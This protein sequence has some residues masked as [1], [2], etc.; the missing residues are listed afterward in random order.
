MI[1]LSQAIS[2]EPD[3]EKIQLRESINLF[4]HIFG[5]RLPKGPTRDEVKQMGGIGITALLMGIFFLF[6]SLILIAYGYG[7]DIF[8]EENC[9]PAL[10]LYMGRACLI[11]SVGW[12]LV[13]W[14]EI[15]KNKNLAKNKIQKPESPWLWKVNW[16]M[17]GTK[18]D[19]R[20]SLYV[21]I[22]ITVFGF[23]LLGSPSWYFITEGNQ[24]EGFG[25]FVISILILFDLIFVSAIVFFVYKSLKFFKYGIS[26]FE[27]LEFPFFTNGAIK[28]QLNNLPK[29][30]SNLTLDLRFIQQEFKIENGRYV[31]NHFQL[32][33]ASKAFRKTPENWK[34]E[35]LIDWSLPENREMD[36]VLNEVGA[37]YWELEVKA[38]TSGIDYH[39]RFILPV[40][41]KP[42][43][44]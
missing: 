6:S 19:L 4:P 35:L 32:Y 42:L 17:D 31:L 22:W 40:Y 9:D 14:I 36:T 23:S 24:L 5:G 12:I 20:T 44:F 13:G 7:Y 16:D 29:E 33:K 28:G 34:G 41:T 15:K 26:K 1:D 43:S 8:D 30:F 18:D 10:G 11:F 2:S 37:K 21:R 38:E 27:F 3:S 25:W 39:S